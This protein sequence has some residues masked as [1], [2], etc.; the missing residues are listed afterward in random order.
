MALPVLFIGHG[1]PMNALEDNVFT[2]TWRK[3]AG[4][5]PRP[6]AILA[7]SAHW[8]TKEPRITSGLHLQTI[9]DFN[10]F[11]PQ[12]HAYNYPAAGDPELALQLISDLAG[13]YS[14]ISD[15]K[16]GL[17]HGVWSVLCQMYPQADIPVLQLSIAAQRT[18]QWHL[19]FGRKLQSLREQNI[20]ILTS[21]NIV[22]NLSLLDWH[23]STTGFKWA[24]DY[25]NQIVTLV[26]ANCQQEL[27]SYRELDNSTLAVPHEDHFLPL[28][29]AIGAGGDTPASVT[30]FN[31]QTLYGSLS[32][33]S[34]CI[35]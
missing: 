2:Q 25:D 15:D 7:I 5:I 31:Q 4:S 26:S 21:G 33:T 29:Y 9:H 18:P 10:G 20:L 22:H 19:E 14:I 23:M 24:S 6:D 35:Y 12:L 32:M 16:W 28:L 30:V 27:C 3:I 11:P 17:D 1:S 8:Y 34:F 13:D